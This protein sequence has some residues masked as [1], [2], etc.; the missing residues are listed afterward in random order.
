MLNAATMH[1]SSR[2]LLLGLLPAAVVGLAA[3]QEQAKTTERA[4]LPV[5]VTHAQKMDLPIQLH[6]PAELQAI[7]QAEVQP[8]EIR[9]Y[10]TKMRVDKGDTVKA[11]QVLARLD[12]TPYADER[13]KLEEA[14]KQ[15]EARQHFAATTM[16]RLEPMAKQNFVGAQD[17]EQAEAEAAT[18]TAALAHAQAA[19]KEA[20]HKLS[21]C[22]L[23]AP[24]SG[25]VTMRYV[26]PGALVGPGNPVV[27]VADETA[28]RIFVNVVERDVSRVRVGE[29]ASLTVD[30]YPHRV[31]RGRVERVVNAIDPKTRTMLVEVD[32]PNPDGALKPGM[33][34]RVAITAEVHRGALVAMAKALQVTEDGTFVFTTDGKVAHRHQVKL[35]YDDGERVEILS[36]LAA[37]DP[38]VIDGQDLLGEGAPVEPHF[39]PSSDAPP[40]AG[41]E[42]ASPPPPPG[43]TA[44]TSLARKP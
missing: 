12:C 38:L 7:Q 14:A 5:V 33:F 8:M 41:P 1:L 17:L 23:I 6:Y 43:A 9:G 40:P 29:E 24:F 44:P 15:A 2:S 20:Q 35:G 10:V 4:A 31:F 30:A 27:S 36:G 39:D 16:A 13:A 19:V 26:D 42:E 34:G 32:I 18:S 37:T 22:D 3:C 25:E 21:Y 11:G 28:M